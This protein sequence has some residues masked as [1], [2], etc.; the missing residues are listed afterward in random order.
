M[1]NPIDQFPVLKEHNKQGATIE[2]MIDKGMDASEIQ[3]MMIK[4]NLGNPIV[5][6]GR[7]I[8]SFSIL[9]HLRNLENLHIE[10]N[11]IIPK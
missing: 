6:Q 4:H 11:F 3:M 7:L 5:C 8:P 9:H 1:I 10:L 2:R